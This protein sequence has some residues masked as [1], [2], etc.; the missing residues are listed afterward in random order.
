MNSNLLRDSLEYRFKMKRNENKVK[1][2]DLNDKSKFL[3]EFK[4]SIIKSKIKV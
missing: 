2:T 3:I 4:P 1:R